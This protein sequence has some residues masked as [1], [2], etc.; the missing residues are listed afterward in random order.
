MS[1]W[2]AHAHICHTGWLWGE[3]AWF[4]FRAGRPTVMWCVTKNINWITS[5]LRI[6][7]LQYL[8]NKFIFWCR[9]QQSNQPYSIRSSK[10]AYIFNY[11]RQHYFR[12]LVNPVVY[13]NVEIQ[14]MTKYYRLFLTEY[15]ATR[16][17]QLW[18]A[19]CFIMILWLK[20]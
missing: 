6:S 15:S 4:A 13:V 8:W 14:F 16:F 12:K 7:I 9:M 19:T 11:C 17:C 3:A 18:P 1:L 2:S 20:L 5:G 10:Y